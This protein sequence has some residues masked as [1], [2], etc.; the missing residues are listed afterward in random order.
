MKKYRT[1]RVSE[2]IHK[3]LIKKAGERQLTYGERT[4]VNDILKELLDA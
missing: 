3:R 1:I 4:S 2:D